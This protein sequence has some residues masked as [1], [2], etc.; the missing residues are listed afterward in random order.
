M[1]KDR[2]GTSSVGTH[3]MASMFLDSVRENDESNGT[4]NLD[5]NSPNAKI[6]S[7]VRLARTSEAYAFLLSIF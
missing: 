2:R 7:E 1:I 4:F 5:V 3:E 6:G